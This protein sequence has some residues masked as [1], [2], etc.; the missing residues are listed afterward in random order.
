MR[1]VLLAALMICT[2]PALAVCPVPRNLAFVVEK[3]IHRSVPGFTE[4]LEV[5]GGAIL[6]STGDLFGN[7][8]I[9]RIDPKTGKVTTLLD[10]GKRYFGEGLT[11]F[12][13]RLYQMTWREHRAFV[14]DAHM[15]PLRELSN[16]REG[17]GLT[18]DA[19][20]LIASDGSSSIF[21]LSPADFSTLGALPVLEEDRPIS[22]LNELEYADG[23]IWAN[24]FESWTVLKISPVTGCVEA[25]ANIASLRARM[26]AGERR[27]IDAEPNFVPNGIAYNSA[28]GAFILTGK[29]WPMLFSGHFV[30]LN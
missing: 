3:T 9:N 23:A 30:D 28:T 15:K 1:H 5:Q 13:G 27:I 14:F 4:G 26:T 6:E 21:F 22:A 12:G 11:Q 17:W 7:S 10:A 20:R 25:R 16:P 18:H 24:V 8:R 2:T 29:N 19:T